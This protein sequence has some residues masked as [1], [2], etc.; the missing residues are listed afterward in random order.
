MHHG[1]GTCLVKRE[2]KPHMTE[3]CES[4]QRPLCLFIISF[5]LLLDLKKSGHGSNWGL[6]SVLTHG[7]CYAH[8]VL[9]SWTAALFT[10]DISCPL[11]S[12]GLFFSY[13]NMM[14]RTWSRQWQLAIL[15]LLFYCF[16][17]SCVSGGRGS[18]SCKWE[19]FCVSIRGGGRHL[20]RF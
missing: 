15:A 12:S 8:A 16:S 1:K 13:L 9:L 6:R 14:P 4:Q 19:H 7:G 18:R 10:N 17:P 11:E 3:A 5:F 20:E 2:K